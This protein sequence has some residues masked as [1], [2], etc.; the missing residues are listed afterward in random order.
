MASPADPGGAPA[1][2][3]P[4][5]PGAAG[6]PPARRRSRIFAGWAITVVVAL[7]LAFGIRAFVFQAFWIPH[8]VH[9]VNAG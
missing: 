1:D 5:I 4:D 2:A 3:A 6:R 8:L 7:S 9:G